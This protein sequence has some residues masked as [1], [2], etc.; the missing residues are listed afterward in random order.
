MSTTEH[1]GSESASTPDAA[2]TQKLRAHAC[3]LC[4]RRKVKC[5]RR[6][7]CAACTRARAECVFRAPAPPRRR[8]RKSPEAMLLARLRRYEEILK[9]LG[10]RIEP[11]GSDTEIAGRVEAMD[12]VSDK[13]MNHESPEQMPTNHKSARVP[14]VEN[15]RIVVKHGKARYLEK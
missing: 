2:D 7:P 14:A 3:V 9:E 15:G 11:Q 6:D 4:Q 12:I 13:P 1:T 8:P 10:V 5:D